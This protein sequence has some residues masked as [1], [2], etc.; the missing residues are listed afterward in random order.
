VTAHVLFL[1]TPPEMVRTNLASATLQLKALGITDIAHFEFMD[2]PPAESMI[3]ALELLYSLGAL[4]D[5]CNLVSGAMVLNKCAPGPVNDEYETLSDGAVWPSNGRVPCRASIGCNVAVLL[6]VR[7]L[8]GSANHR[9]LLFRGI[10]V[11]GQ[12]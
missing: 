12:P 9:C 10:C 1:S 6:Q 11:F 5:G 7:L 4:D 3:R 8:G 2:A